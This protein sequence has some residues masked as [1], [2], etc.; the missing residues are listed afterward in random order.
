MIDLTHG[1]RAARRAR[2]RARAARSRCRYLPAGVHLAV[3]DPGVGGERRRASRCGSRTAA[4][5]VGPDNGLLA[6]AAEAGG[7]V[8]E[9]VDIG[10]LAVRAAS[11]CRRRSTGAT[12]SPLSRRGSPAAPRSRDAGEP[13]DPAGLVALE[14]PARAGRRRGT[15]GA[16]A[17]HRPLRQRRSSTSSGPRCSRLRPGVGVAAGSGRCGP[18]PLRADVRRRRRRRAASLR[19]RLPAAGASRS[20]RGTPRRGW[21][22]RSTTSCGSGWCEGG[23]G[24]RAVGAVDRAGVRAVA[25]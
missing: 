12:C 11:R 21:G 9:A 24:M 10:A 17:V 22:S 25:E 4:S 7:G 8:V 6:P 14:L 2:G 20:T 18:C 23:G 16:R 3:V 19:G 5:L 15:G 13:L 1:V